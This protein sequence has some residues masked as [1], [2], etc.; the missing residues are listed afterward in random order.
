MSICVPQEDLRHHQ[1][2]R[3]MVRQLFSEFYLPK[4]GVFGLEGLHLK[5]CFCVAGSSFGCDRIDLFHPQQSDGC[6][7][8]YMYINCG[9]SVLSLAAYPYPRV[10][11]TAS[12]MIYI[13]VSTCKAHHR[14]ASIRWHAKY[15][16]H[17]R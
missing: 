3:L 13:F 2:L 4:H 8:V 14:Q 5:S 10:A 16:I 17:R 9:F 6:S 12:S 1:P 7:M 11:V 15:G